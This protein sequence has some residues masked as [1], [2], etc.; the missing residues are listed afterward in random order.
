MSTTQKTR[1]E[2]PSRKIQ[3]SYRGVFWFV[4]L[5]ILLLTVR[6]LMTTFASA[7]RSQFLEA[8]ECKVLAIL[9]AN[10][11]KIEL[12]DSGHKIDVELLSTI[13]IEGK[14]NSAQAWLEQHI[15]GKSCRIELDRYRIDFDNVGHVYLFDGDELVNET[16]IANGFL[17]FKPIQGNSR[18][19][20]KRLKGAGVP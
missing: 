14:E 11:M 10:R 7:D 5:V 20:Q 13:P 2:P 4:L 12:S 8:G 19:M 18:L 15:V 6:I 1:T 3:Q 16:M 9:G 17:R